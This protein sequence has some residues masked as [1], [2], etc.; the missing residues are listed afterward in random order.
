MQ[1]E[2]WA[3]VGATGVTGR[4]V[5][6]C[7]LARGHR[8]SLIG[9]DAAR[10]RAAVGAN[11]LAMAVADIEDR[12]ALADAFKNRRLVLNAAGPFTR[13]GAPVMAAAMDA[14][15]DYLDLNGE[16][17]PLEQLFASDAQAQAQARGVA[18]VGGAGFGVAAGEG[19]AALAVARLG[20]ADWV[21]LG[22]AVDSAFSSQGVADSTLE[23]L[24]A[25]GFEVRDGRLAPRNLAA[26]RWR[27]G[28]VAFASAPLAELAALRRIPGV[29]RAVAGVPM[30][31]AQAVVLSVIAPVLPTLMRIPFVRGQMANAGG[32]GAGAAVRTDHASRVWV[33]AGAG[34]R[35][36]RGRLDAGEGFA[37]AADIAVLAVEEALNRRIAPGAHSP[38]SAFGADFIARVPGVRISFDPG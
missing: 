21:R 8:P 3:L 14:G 30:A 38:A 9:R 5:L 6:E 20:G 19:L 31:G 18:L 12:A 28:G 24:A 2:G 26:R 13:T 37:V 33:T 22:V 7:A 32:H 23:V 16:L 1:M 27:E 10:L 36:V 29:K 11:D 4:M 15:A 17:A 34:K 25:G 35:R